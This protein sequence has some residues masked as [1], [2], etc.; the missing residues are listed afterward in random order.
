MRTLV[1]ILVTAVVLFPL[2]ASA[3]IIHI[4]GDY[5]T[6]QEGIDNSTHG[7]TVLVADGTYTG[8]GNR[9]IDFGGKAIL[10]MSETGPENSIIDCQDS[11]RGFYF[12]SGETE[13]SKVQGFTVRNGQPDGIYC[14][15]ASPAIADNIITA[16]DVYG[17]QCWDNAS[18][19][20]ESCTISMNGGGGIYC[21]YFC[22]P[23]ITTCTISTNVGSGIQC[24]GPCAPTITGCTISG[25]TDAYAGGGIAFGSDCFG[26]IDS[27]TISGNEAVVGGGIAC[28]SYASPTIT[29][30][31]I[32]EN[33]AHHGGGIDCYQYSSPTISDNLVANNWC[34]YDAG[35]ISCSYY[36]SPTIENCVIVGNIADFGYGGAISCGDYSSP[37]IEQCILKENTAEWAGGG[38]Y[39]DYYC[40]LNLSYCIIVEN[41]CISG[42]GGGVNFERSSPTIQSCVLVYNTA[43]EPGGGIA[44]WGFEVVIN[45]IVWG[46]TP[47][48][49]YGD[50]TVTYS[51]VQEG[52]PGTGNIDATPIFVGPYNDDF[53]LRWRSP[54]IDAGDP[55]PQ[56]NDPD[57]TRNDMGCF[58]FDQAVLGVVEVY[59]HDEPI[60][61]PP[62]G[63]SFV[64]DMWVFNFFG[65]P[66]RGDIWTYAFVP[67]MGRYGPIE[68]Y[69]NVRI[70]ADSIGMNDIRQNVPGL[71]PEGDYTIVAYVGRY[72]S[73]IID[74][75]YFYF[76]KEGSVGGG[77]TSWFEGSE[78]LKGG[79]L[80]ESNLPSHYA[81]SQNYPNPFNAS[82]VINYELPVDGHV[83]LEVYNTLG[84]RVATLVDSKQQAGY[85]S[86]VWDASKISSG[87]YFYKLT[88][89]DYNE[90]K[91]MMLVK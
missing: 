72:P 8:D 27:C 26:T 2:T 54:C 55:D 78:W 35:G 82:T 69:R 46:N 1:T 12:H 18:P 4:P 33:V 49:I 31:T 90:T 63:G 36:S 47:D 11:G 21:D 45:S 91:R 79:D 5:G 10:V 71:A 24:W 13:G 3:T 32:S 70:P 22:S 62:G 44:S 64:Y 68:L 61:I 48:Q 81:V 15:L 53:H 9:D 20:I 52:W 23:T 65:H 67:G 19:I 28:Q 43:G 38:V 87:L 34:S 85:R 59:P 50:P 30:N 37:W 58:Y 60:V 76:S 29:H 7:D 89:G 40:D 57:G 25:N 88:A 6:I 75:S 17:I 14:D 83:R 77:V 51:D 73:T 16:N 80:A 56:Y 66:G 84:Q 74:S 86:V 42:Y 39:C 41:V